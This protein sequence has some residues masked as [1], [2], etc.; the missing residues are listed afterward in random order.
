MAEGIMLNPTIRYYGWSALCIE[1]A[2]GALLFDPFYRKYC[3]AQWFTLEDFAHATVVCAT[4][5]HEEHY[6]DIPAVVKRSGAT[7]VAHRTVCD[8]L[9]WRSHIAPEKLVSIGEF[10]TRELRG[11]RISAFKWKHRDINL[12]K[13]LA[14]AVFQGNSA[15]LSWAWSSASKAPFYAPYM[16]FHVELPDGLTILN[17][18]EGFNSKMTDREI[19][20]LGRRYRTDVLLA[21]MQL[22]FVSDVARGAAALNPK[23]VVLYPPH[24]HFH[25]MMGA[26]SEPWT[27]FADAVRARVPA[28]QVVIAEP[29]TAVDVAS[30]AVS[31]QQPSVRA[32]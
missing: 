14:R 9:R 13:A 19:T 28:A 31:R 25:R 2:N 8:Y 7:V 11:F 27:R 20:E 12:Y 1:T 17:Y 24:D 5:G 6:L 15:Q 21:G 18:N 29:G 23:V 30:G 10:E 32:A 16:G 22:N 26:I 3:G 4:H